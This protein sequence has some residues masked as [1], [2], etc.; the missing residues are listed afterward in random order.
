MS[1]SEQGE[2]HLNLS[3]RER[4]FEREFRK[5]LSIWHTSS[6]WPGIGVCAVLTGLAFYL[7]TLPYPPF[8]LSDGAHPLS[9]VLLALL[10]GMVLRNI[11]PAT[12]QL[13]PGVDIVI[14]RLL[15]LGIVLLGARLDFYDLLRVGLH[16]LLGAIV[17]ILIIIVTTGYLAKFFKVGDKLAMLIGIG[18][19]ICGSS[20]IIAAAPVIESEE[21]DIAISIAT[22]NLLGVLSMLLFPLLGTLIMLSPEVYGIWCGLSIH[23]T[24]QVIAAGFAH[25]L[26]G[27]QAGEVATIVKLTRISL[28]GPAVFGVGLAYAYRRRREAVYIGHTVD[29]R[30]LIP[31]FILFFLAMAF[32]RTIGFLPEITFHMTDRFIFGQGDHTIHLANFLAK[33]AKWFITGAMAGVGLITEFRAMKTGGLSPFALGLGA[34]VIISVLGLAYANL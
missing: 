24:P 20:A 10:L 9:A 12:A 29:Y 21:R 26:D 31:T 5:K 13:K 8:T 6:P 4:A 25:H 14:K 18:T 15:P 23:A 28:L 16:V 30:K 7:H 19:A 11:I 33:T 27:Q 32:L 2:K 17:L 1:C 3:H 22:V 34:T